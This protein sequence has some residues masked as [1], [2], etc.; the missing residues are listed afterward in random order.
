MRKASNIGGVAQV[1]RSW[2]VAAIVAMAAVI[3]VNVALA[4]RPARQDDQPAREATGQTAQRGGGDGKGADAAEGLAI[5]DPRG[6]LDALAPA[7]RKAALGAA[8]A[9]LEGEGF[10]PTTVALAVPT[11]PTSFR[12]HADDPVQVA[13][14]LYAP[15]LHRTLGVSGF[16]GGAGWHGFWVADRASRGSDP[17]VEDV[18][19]DDQA[20]LSPVIGDDAAAALAQAWA[21][22]ASAQG[23]EEASSFVS[24][25]TAR[26]TDAGATLTVG[27]THAAPDHMGEQTDWYDATWDGTAWTFSQVQA[28]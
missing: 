13:V 8:S 5:Y 7:D 11:P 22:W 16:T 15:A 27:C 10:D 2:L 3:A 24:A 14:T 23:I 26:R 12:T 6:L 4:L 18:G 20:A 17:S 25:G 28:R 21:D 9:F 1:P 19:L